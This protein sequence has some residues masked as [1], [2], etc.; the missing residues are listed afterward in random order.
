MRHSERINN[1][2][3][4]SQTSQYSSTDSP[5]NGLESCTPDTFSS[6][7]STSEKRRK[8]VHRSPHR[9]VRLLHIPFLQ[10]TPVEAES[11]LERDFVHVAALY[12]KCKSIDHQPFRIDLP[13]G[14][15][16][17]DFLLRFADQSAC[18]VE[19]KPEKF[20]K[21]HYQKFH[22][23]HAEFARRQIEFLVALDSHIHRLNRPANAQRIRRYGKGRINANEVEATITL[24]ANQT[25]AE[26]KELLDA[27]IS[28]ETLAYLVCTHK[29]SVGNNLRLNDT[30]L[31]TLVRTNTEGGCDAV[32]FAKWFVA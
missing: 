13:S 27:G 12:P 7:T 1:S 10:A 4:A 11:A 6:A 21:G 32:H 18:V 17:P 31:V 25:T 22:Q 16:T 23:A 8:V 15:Y 29:V 14:S 30:D 5:P 9:T 28:R 3:A 2:Q 24:L 26:V 19:V 20:V